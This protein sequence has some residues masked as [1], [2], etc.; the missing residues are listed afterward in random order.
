MTI[1]TPGLD[2]ARR[3]RESVRQRD[4]RSQLERLTPTA[5]LAARDILTHWGLSEAL[6]VRLVAGDSGMTKSTYRS[7][8]AAAQAGTPVASLSDDEL[9]RCSLIVQIAQLLQGL[10][11]GDQAR[12]WPTRVSD[13]PLWAGRSP[14]EYMLEEGFAG[15][16]KVR[17]HLLARSL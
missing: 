12:L 8:V 4:K 2:P 14:A 9:R 6:Q 16:L 1:L 15:L 10:Y 3:R 17:D 7:K 13:Q 11:G 5:L